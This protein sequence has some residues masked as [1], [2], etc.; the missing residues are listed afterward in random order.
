[1]AL[2]RSWKLPK[3][4]LTSAAPLSC[5]VLAVL[6]DDLGAGIGGQAGA[7]LDGVVVGLD[8]HAAEGGGDL[9]VV[10]VALFV[11]VDGAAGEQGG[12]QA[13]GQAG[14]QARIKKL[15][16]VGACVVVVRGFGCI[17]SLPRE[18]FENDTPARCKRVPATWERPGLCGQMRVPKKHR[19]LGGSTLT[20]TVGNSQATGETGKPRDSNAK[21]SRPRH[22]AAGS[23]GWRS[24]SQSADGR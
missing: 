3:L 16:A 19:R 23:F 11:R 20:Y 9:H 6:V 24:R 22:Q 13:E 2:T 4:M 21:R 10:A 18:S 14:D 15:P 8:R 1:M 12:A 7:D 5:F 17:S